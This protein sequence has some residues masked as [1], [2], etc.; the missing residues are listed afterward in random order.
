MNALC[1]RLLVRSQLT[2]Q[3]RGQMSSSVEGILQEILICVFVLNALEQLEISNEPLPSLTVDPTI[4][5]AP[6]QLP[7]LQEPPS[8]AQALLLTVK[9]IFKLETHHIRGFIDTILT[10]CHPQTIRQDTLLYKYFTHTSES[11]LFS[12]LQPVSISDHLTKHEQ[13]ISTLNAKGAQESHTINQL[14][15]HTTP[16]IVYISHA[17]GLMAKDT[18]KSSNPYCV[19]Q[20]QG[21]Q[22]V[23]P[24]HEKSLSPTFDFHV[25]LL[26]TGNSPVLIILWNRSSNPRKPDA[27]LGLVTLDNSQ[28]STQFA[29]SE[30]QKRTKKSHVSGQLS[31]LFAKLSND[32]TPNPIP[33]RSIYKS[34]PMDPY[35]SFASVMKQSLFNDYLSL[36]GSEASHPSRLV[37]LIAKT[38]H[39]TREF[40][41]FW[42]SVAHLVNLKRWLICIQ[43]E[44]FLQCTFAIQSSKQH[45]IFI[46]KTSKA[47]LTTRKYLLI[48]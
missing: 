37:D 5:I 36:N 46:R 32:T 22:H 33:L 27:F 42:Y 26:M 20:Y 2:L 15:T 1:E 39:I 8:D 4:N 41:V 29:V 30:V 40:Q 34:I 11:K 3:T 14:Y 17:T 48:R 6:P 47:Q 12:R 19:I 13:P 38:W 35:K 7:Y 18:N 25:A 21:I 23:S 44:K 45:L 9:D 43:L 16:V 24:I 31:I 10:T 28:L